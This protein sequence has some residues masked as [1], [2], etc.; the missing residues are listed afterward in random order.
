MN[1]PGKSSGGI[2]FQ[3]L[4]AS[5]SVHIN[6][7]NQYQ[8]ITSSVSHIQ[9]QKSKLRCDNKIILQNAVTISEF[10]RHIINWIIKNVTL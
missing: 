8:S 3:L 10:I 2:L 7:A 5:L 9:L 4:L 1:T 6:N